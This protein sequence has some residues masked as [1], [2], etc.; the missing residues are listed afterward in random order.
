MPGSLIKDIITNA[1]LEIFNGLYFQKN[2]EKG[3]PFENE[4]IQLRKAEGRI[5]DVATVAKLPDVEVSH[6]LLKEWRIRKRSANRLIQFL[7]SRK[8]KTI[9]EVGCGNGWLIRCIHSALEA[10]CLGIDRNETELRQAVKTSGNAKSLAFIYADF[11][12]ELFAKPCADA[13]I[14]ASVIQYFPDAK[15]LLERSVAMLNPGGQVH[16]LDS[17]FY[18]EKTI[19]AARERSQKYFSAMGQPEMQFHY[20]HHAWNVL[21]GFNV[22]IKYNPNTLLNRLS[23]KVDGNS[24]FPWIVIENTL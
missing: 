19:R 17:P 16:I 15:S 1:S 14:L 10:D 24:P 8:P 2:L 7:K 9:I 23:Q 11:F 21:D 12:S 18:S 20:F 5:Y 4:Y 3:L 6:P 22:T 13:I